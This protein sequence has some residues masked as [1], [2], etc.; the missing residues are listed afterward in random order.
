MKNLS[1]EQLGKMRDNLAQFV[2]DN[3]REYVGQNFGTQEMED[4]SWSVPPLAVRI[5]TSIVEKTYKTSLDGVVATPPE[6]KTI[7]DEEDE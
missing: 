5:A 6:Y 1:K 7:Y 3:I 4:P 2:A